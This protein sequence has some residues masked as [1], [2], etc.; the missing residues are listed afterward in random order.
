MASA[1][2]ICCGVGGVGKT[3]TA[4]A[5]AVGLAHAGKRVAVLTIDPA[6]RLADA[7]GVQLGNDPQP[8]DLPGGSGTLHALM[9]DRKATF[10]A[11]VRRY[12]PD[13]E[14]ADKLIANRYYGAISTRLSGSQEYMALEKLLALHEDERFDTLVIDTPPTRHALDF[15][16]APERVRSVMDRRVLGAIVSPTGGSIFSRASQKVLGVV[17]RMAGESVLADLQEFF[18]LL[19]G[20]SQGFRDRGARVREL[21]EHS[22]TRFWLVLGADDPG[23]DDALE[24]LDTLR[25][26]KLVVGGILVNRT[27]PAPSVEPVPAL[28]CPKGVDPAAWG[29][30]TARL[31]SRHAERLQR[32]QQQE[33]A[34]ERLRPRAA[35]APWIAIEERA[36]GVKSVGDLLDIAQDVLPHAR[37]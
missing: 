33:E 12:A 28:P 34:A 37:T 4:A 35:G 25:D 21:L 17:Y 22:Q 14:T 11:V 15:L 13:P 7:L 2:H 3:T 24:F 32:A 18:G 30:I 19:G 20:L 23:R 1:I 6:Q 5:L 16:R 26:D 29:E 31:A 27:A 8:V 9:L 10:D 36:E